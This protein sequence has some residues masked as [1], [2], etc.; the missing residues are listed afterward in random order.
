MPINKYD[1]IVTIENK[2][3]ERVVK[4]NCCVLFNLYDY[5]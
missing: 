2:K 5:T 3:M 1:F 4:E